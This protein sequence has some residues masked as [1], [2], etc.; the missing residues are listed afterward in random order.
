MLETGY[1]FDVCK[2]F[3]NKFKSAISYEMTPQDIH[4][5]GTLTTAETMLQYDDVD[6]V[7]IFPKLYFWYVST[8]GWL[9]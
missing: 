8:E 2:M 1:E 4:S 7:T 9:S 3:F 5:F 6:E